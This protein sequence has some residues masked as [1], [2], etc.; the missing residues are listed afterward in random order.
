MQSVSRAQRFARI[1]KTLSISIDA[2][3][4]ARLN[5]ENRAS[6][7][8]GEVI[9]TFDRGRNSNIC[10]ALLDHGRVHRKPY[11]P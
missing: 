10:A 2:E 3:E 4:R 5:A 9:I 6:A 11:C 8:I 1:S 7:E